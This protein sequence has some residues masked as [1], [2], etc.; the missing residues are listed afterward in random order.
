[1]STDL[2]V[3]YL[4]EYV[5][6][7]VFLATV[8]VDSCVLTQPQCVVRCK[9][10]YLGYSTCRLPGKLAVVYTKDLHLKLKDAIKHLTE[11]IQAYVNRCM[12]DIDIASEDLHILAEFYEENIV[13]T[14]AGVIEKLADRIV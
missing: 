13:T 14:C 2:T 11:Q 12:N 4:A 6:N 10:T 1:M 9:A 5:D 7:K 8:F 3:Y